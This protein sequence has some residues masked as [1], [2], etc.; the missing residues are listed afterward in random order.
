MNDEEYR[1]QCEVRTLIRER[2]EFGDGHLLKFLNNKHVEKR[3]DRLEYD[4]QDQWKKGNR[5]TH[6]DWR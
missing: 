6:G 1:H 2:I 4:I 3:R 5:G